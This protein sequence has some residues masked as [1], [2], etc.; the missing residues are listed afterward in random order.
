MLVAEGISQALGSFRAMQEVGKL[1]GHMIWARTEGSVS[2]A[3]FL[4]DLPDGICNPQG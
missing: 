2:D 3:D 4:P 1:L